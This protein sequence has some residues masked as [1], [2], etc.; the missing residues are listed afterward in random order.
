MAACRMNDMFQQHVPVLLNETVD[1]LVL[2]PHGVYVDA[3]FGRGSHS[4]AILNRLDAS[5]RLIAFDKDPEACAYAKHHFA[6]DARFTII[7]HSFAH[8]QTELT[9]LN[10]VGNVTGILFDL[11]VSSPQLDNPERGF[12]FVRSGILD[13][14]MDTTRGVSA[15]EWLATVDEKT[16]ADVL[17]QYGEEKCS[18]RIARAIVAARAITPIT[19]TLQLAEII[20]QVMPKQKK[21][22]DKHP[23]TRSFQAIRIAINEELTDLQLALTQALEVLAI[24]GRLAVISFH[25]LEDR[26]V[27]QFIKLHEKGEELPRGLPVKGSAFH[28]RLISV[29]KPIKPSEQEVN[30]NPRARSAILRIAEKRL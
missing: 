7:H 29:G 15:K 5:S 10:L 13:M 1:H 21:P 3:T 16:L 27:K 18:R 4:Q 14:R 23:A 19:T 30:A 12:S 8:L 20:K 26:L 9:K 2:A 28:S 6:H 22:Q 25:S 24:G 11:G 17:W